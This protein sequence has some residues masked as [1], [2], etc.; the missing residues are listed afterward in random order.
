M[1]LGDE[2]MPLPKRFGHDD[3][4]L[5]R[6]QGHAR[7]DHWLVGL[8]AGGEEG[9]EDDDVVPAGVQFPVGL[10]G[11]AGSPQAEAALQVHVAQFKQLVV[12]S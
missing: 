4:V 12:W 7:A 8:V 6:V 10:I 9:G 3:E 5:G 1:L 11:Q 2:E